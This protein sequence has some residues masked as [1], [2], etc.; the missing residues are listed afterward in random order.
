MNRFKSWLIWLSRIHRSRGFGIQS[1]ADYAFVRYVINEHWPY[2]A[3]SLLPKDDWL[4]RKLGRLYFRLANW[5]Q[6][7]QI[8]TDDYQEYWQAGCQRLCLTTNIETVELARLTIE[9][10]VGFDKLL[11]MCNDQSVLVIEGIHRDWERWHNIEQDNRIGTTFDLYY[12]GII[13]FDKRHYKHHY[14]INF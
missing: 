9:D 11:G 14:C 8:L 12:C 7:L 5:R 1:P 4:T 2:Y 3:Y 6:P 13:F 10:N